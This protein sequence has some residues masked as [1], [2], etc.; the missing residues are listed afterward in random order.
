MDVRDKLCVVTGGAS[1]IGRALVDRFVREGARHVVLVDRAAAESTDRITARQ[2]DVTD[3]AAVAALVAEIEAT[4]GPIDLFCSNAGILS[5]DP[6][7]DNVASL[8]TA[9]WN[10]AWAVNVMAHIFAARAVLPSMIARKAGYFLHTVSA[11]G[12]LSQIGAAAYSTTKHAAIGFA[13][14]LAITHRDHGIRVSVLCPQAVATPMIDDIPKNGADVDGILSADAVVDAA[15]EGLARESFLI[16]PHTRVSDYAANKS[17][18]YDRWI[19]GMAKARRSM[20]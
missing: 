11:A 18:N 13:E 14:S 7:F 3:E 1:G 15:I 16:L 8:P 9:E 17:A 6:D 4:I 5:V 12:L 2:V 19:G 10:R 20:R